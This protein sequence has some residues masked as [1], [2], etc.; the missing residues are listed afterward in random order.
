MKRNPQ[1]WQRPR[2][3]LSKGAALRCRLRNSSTFSIG[4]AGVN[5]ATPSIRTP[6]EG[7][8]TPP[9]WRVGVD[10]YGGLLYHLTYMDT[11]LRKSNATF[12]AHPPA[13]PSPVS[14]DCPPAQGTGFRFRAN[15]SHTFAR[16]D[17][18]VAAMKLQALARPVAGGPSGPPRGSARS[19]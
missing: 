18:A 7:A 19:R 9:T 4:C 5:L 1:W 2:C 16:A 13:L 17:A 6:G 14:G 3:R 10:D 15:R 12:A 8:V 11:Q